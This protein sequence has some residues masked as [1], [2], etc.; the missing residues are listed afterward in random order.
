[1]GKKSTY[2]SSREKFRDQDRVRSVAVGDF[3]AVQFVR[4]DPGEN[5][6]NGH[7]QFDAGPKKDPFLSFNYVFGSQC[8]L[9]DKLIKSK[10]KQ[11][12]DPHPSYKHSQPGEGR[13]IQ[14]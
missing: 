7:D 9:N 2:Q 5:D 10:I 4:D 13:V 14:G 11:I 8:S 1:S 3:I 6:D 12:G